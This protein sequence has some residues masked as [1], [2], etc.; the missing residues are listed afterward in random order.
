[1]VR[2]NRDP[3]VDRVPGFDRP[4]GAA[5]EGERDRWRPGAAAVARHRGPDRDVLVREHGHPA[6]DDV[7]RIGGT[8]G[9]GWLE[10]RPCEGMARRV[11]NAA[12]E[13]GAAAYSNPAG[14]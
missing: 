7:T 4:T 8:D 10:V 13:V 6:D 2:A 12:F 5:G 11:P 9:G 1:A 3:R 14:R